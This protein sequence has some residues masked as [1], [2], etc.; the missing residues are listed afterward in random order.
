MSIEHSLCTALLMYTAHHLVKERARK[1]R[2]RRAWRRSI[3]ASFFEGLL[4]HPLLTPT[5]PLVD[6]TPD[7]ES[8]HGLCGVT[9]AATITAAVMGTSILWASISSLARLCRVKEASPGDPRRFLLSSMVPIV[10]GEI[11][12]PIL[13]CGRCHTL[14]IRALD[15]LMC[16]LPGVS[17][18][19]IDLGNTIFRDFQWPFIFRDL[20]NRFRKNKTRSTGKNYDKFR[21]SSSSRNG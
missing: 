10:T 5:T 18:K 4:R 12:G 3:S 21:N 6:A 19:F 2:S 9:N 11:P 17:R 8:E 13:H 1:R 20:G 14:D 16:S 7:I 15:D